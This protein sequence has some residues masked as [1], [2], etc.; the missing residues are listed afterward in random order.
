M[1]GIV[2]KIKERIKESLDRRKQKV[3]GS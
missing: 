3:G 2:G 1:N